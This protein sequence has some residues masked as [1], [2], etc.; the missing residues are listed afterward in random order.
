MLL[1][2]RGVSHSVCK[3][4]YLWSLNLAPGARKALRELLVPILW[5]KLRNIGSALCGGA[6]GS[7][8]IIRAN[9]LYSQ[10]EGL[11]SKRQDDH[12]SD[13]PLSISAA[14]CRCC[15]RQGRPSHVNQDKGTDRSS[16]QAPFSGDSKLWQLTLKP[17][18]SQYFGYI[19]VTCF[20]LPTFVYSYV[21]DTLFTRLYLKKN[22]IG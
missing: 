22:Q 20:V 17:N 3:V 21:S 16:G 10:R 11:P 7:S 15:H 2:L 5:Q 13:I 12:P 9:H 4:G 18:L 1:T 8:N 6:N 19:C 14:T